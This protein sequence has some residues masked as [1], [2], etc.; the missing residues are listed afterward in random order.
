LIVPTAAL[1]YVDPSTETIDAMMTAIDVYDLDASAALFSDDAVVVQPHMGGLQEL[2]V[3]SDQIRWW[4]GN[5]FAQHVHLAVRGAPRAD[6]GH[7]LFSEFL[8]VDAYQQL[9]LTEVEVESDVVLAP[10]SR[11]SSLTT[12]LSPDTARGIR[13]VP[14]F[15]PAV[16]ASGSPPVHV[17]VN[18]AVADLLLMHHL[19]G[20]GQTRQFTDAGGL[21]FYGASI[22][23]MY[24][25]VGYYLDRILRGAYPADLPVEQPTAFGF[26]VNQ[27]SARALGLAIPPEVAQQVTQWVQ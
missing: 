27:T 24:R 23:A 3:G 22:E 16:S 8:A 1:A 15:G 18:A 12:T 6:S 7:I 5:L 25:R 14:A 19:A 10:D 26:V 20:S 9:G 4:L 13:G 2:Y 11:I 21:M 17:D